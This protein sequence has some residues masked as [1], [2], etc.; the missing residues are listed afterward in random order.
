MASSKWLGQR[1][2]NSPSL[3]RGAFECAATGHTAAW[4]VYSVSQQIQVEATILEELRSQ[5]LLAMPEMLNS[6]SQSS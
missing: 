3:I 4:E 5:D 2:L 1:N 6:Q